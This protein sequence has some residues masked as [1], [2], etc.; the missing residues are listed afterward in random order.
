MVGLVGQR[1][2]HMARG[3]RESDRGGLNSEGNG[4]MG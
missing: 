3:Q 2:A 4:Q 1:P